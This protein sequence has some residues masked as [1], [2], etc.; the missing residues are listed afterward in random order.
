MKKQ[1][2]RKLGIEELQVRYG[3]S[4]ELANILWERAYRKALRKARIE[5]VGTDFNISREVYA[6]T[7]YNGSQLFEIDVQE[8]SPLVN[9]AEQFK[10]QDIEKAFTEARFGNM[11]KKY[12][13]VQDYLEQYKSG[14]IS[15]KQ[16]RA[17]VKMF[18]DSNIEY[19][20]AGS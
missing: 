10:G 4:P 6:S 16:F 9:I 18:R 13:E 11:A 2:W 15:Y 5:G 3:Y 19:Q 12:G 17:K 1:N 20:K 14:Q 8:I 7:F